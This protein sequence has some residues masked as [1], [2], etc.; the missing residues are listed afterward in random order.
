MLMKYWFVPRSYTMFC[1]VITA[2]NSN[3]SPMKIARR[4]TRQFRFC[5]G[6]LKEKMV[7]KHEM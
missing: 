1:M 2:K 6:V 3:D 7:V 5:F 4:I